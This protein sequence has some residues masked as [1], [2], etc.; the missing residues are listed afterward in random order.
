MQC[1]AMQRNAMRNA[2]RPRRES[3]ATLSER[4]C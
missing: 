3:H 4:E 1:N 2:M